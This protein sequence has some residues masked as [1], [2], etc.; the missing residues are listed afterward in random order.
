MEVRC[1]IDMPSH[2]RLCRC[3]EDDHTEVCDLNLV[4]HRIAYAETE[5]LFDGI[6]RKVPDKL[7]RNTY[8]RPDGAKL[9]LAITHD[10]GYSYLLFPVEND[11]WALYVRQND[12]DGTFWGRH[13]TGSPELVGETYGAIRETARQARRAAA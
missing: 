3:D 11:K 13:M 5:N 4:L 7:S 2:K 1:A 10:W 6:S 8:G 12:A 9:A